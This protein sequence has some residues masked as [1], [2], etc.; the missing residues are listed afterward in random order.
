MTYPINTTNGSALITPTMPLGVLQDGTLDSSTGVTLIGR[1]YPSYG[2]IQN[3]NFIKLL[4]NF[5][6]SQPPNVSQ[7]ALLLL[8]GTLWFDTAN[9]ILNV[10]DG[11]EFIPASQRIVADSAPTAT[12]IGDQW[13]DSVNQQLRSWNGTI[14]KL[15]GPAYTAGQGKSGAFV[16]TITD[17]TGATHTVVAEYINNHPVTVTSIDTAFTVN[18]AVSTDYTSFTLIQPGVNLAVN[19]ILHG[20]ATNSNTVGSLSPTVFA[21]N[22]IATSFA[23]DIAVAGNLVFSNA[24]VSTANGS[25]ILQNKNHGGNVEVFL[26]TIS[27][28]NVCGLS[29]NG[30]T[31]HAYVHSDPINPLGIATKGYA[32]AINNAVNA[33]LS[34]AVGEINSNVTAVYTDYVGNISVVIATTNANLLAVQSSTNA[35]ITAANLA[36]VSANV[37]M[38]AYVNDQFTA[39]NTALAHGIAEAENMSNVAVASLNTVLSSRIAN[40]QS[41]IDT[42]INPEITTLNNEV[43]TIVTTLIPPLAPTDSPA[44]TGTPTAPT[45]NTPVWSTAVHTPQTGDNSGNVAT[46]AFVISAISG[47]KF[48]YTVSNQP[49]SG[50]VTGDFWFQIGG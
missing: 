8:P 49:P 32:D 37:G 44:F 46:T 31:G 2:E 25:L 5:A 27:E 35:N 50:G 12:N 24:N 9:N 19:T 48:N 43:Q 6:N 11:S 14:W 1:N 39:T 3:E 18:S 26:N 21:R 13:W 28:G 23:S 29:L 45:T 40:V 7:N 42:T 36:I 34:I 20:T 17:T 47:Q 41:Y 16:E 38:N 30:T 33:N 4:Q 10:Y 22:D 15:V